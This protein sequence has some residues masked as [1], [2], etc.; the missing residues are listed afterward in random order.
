V[1]EPPTHVSVTGQHIEGGVVGS[2]D[3][4]PIALAVLDAVGNPAAAVDVNDDA[5]SLFLPGETWTAVT[6]P[7]AAN[8]IYA[9]D[10]VEEI[11]PEPIEFD[12][13]WDITQAGGQ[14]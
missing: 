12:L 2:C 9:F 6:P 5:I 3:K 11:G 8:F 4:C 13:N 7:V 1:N 10:G 14:P